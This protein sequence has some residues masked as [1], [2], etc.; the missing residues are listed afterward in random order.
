MKLSA[1]KDELCSSS[2]LY[3]APV[4]EKAGFVCWKSDQINWF[5]RMGDVLQHIHICLPNASA[6]ACVYF[7]FGAHS[8]IH[9]AEPNPG[10]Y[11]KAASYCGIA[12]PLMEPY[13]FGKRFAPLNG[14]SPIYYAVDLPRRGAE[15]LEEDIVPLLGQLDGAEQAYQHHI[16]RQRHLAADLGEVGSNLKNLQFLEPRLLDEILFFR[17]VT[18]YEYVLHYLDYMSKRCERDPDRDARI[19]RACKTQLAQKRLLL[20]DGIHTQAHLNLLKNALM[21]AEW[22]PFDEVMR[23]RIKLNSV[24]LKIR[25]PELD[26]SASL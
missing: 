18:A 5:R 11:T 16:K 19:Y 14:S 15:C 3:Y 7:V 1:I 2:A 10:L 21:Q 22:E 12:P 23:Q 20:G 26:A 9:W 6:P 13:H 4:L 17:D 24:E 8:L 25:L